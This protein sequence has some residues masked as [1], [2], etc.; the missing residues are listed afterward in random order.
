M[1]TAAIIAALELGED[2]LVSRNRR[3][4]GSALSTHTGHAKIPDTRAAMAGFPKRIAHLVPLAGKEDDEF[5]E[6]LSAEFE[7]DADPSGPKPD[8]SSGHNSF[9]QAIV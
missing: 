6:Q 4:A 7:T 1:V 9:R 8:Y 5:R 2:R 3:A